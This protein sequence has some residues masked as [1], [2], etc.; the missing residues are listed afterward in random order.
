MLV[1]LSQLLAWLAHYRYFLLFP[2]A[3]FEGPIVTILAGFL[4]SQ[5]ILSFLGAFAVLAI[6]DLVGDSLY[7]AIGRWGRNQFIE[8][9]GKY[10]GVTPS[11]LIRVE[12]HF[13]RHSGKTLLLGKL[14]QGIG[15]LI[16]V[17]AGAADMPYGKFLW[18]NTLGTIPKT[19]TLLV[20]GFFFGQA[21]VELNRYLDYT[22]WGMVILAL[23]LVLFYALVMKRI[24]K[25]I[26][27][28][29]NLPL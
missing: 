7:Y 9:W 17:A 18:F 5:N 6:G 28:S 26:S 14:T 2:A 8:R 4:A 25:K 21:Y 10:I 23:L 20:I 24:A 29:S 22:T 15:G 12:E 16:L 3:V 1:P 11:R 27:A 19:L 13:K